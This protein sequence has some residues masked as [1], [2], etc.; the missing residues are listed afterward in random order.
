MTFWKSLDLDQPDHCMFWAP[1][2]LGYFGFLWSAEFTLSS[3]STFC[4]LIH[5]TV[6]DIA[7]DLVVPSCLCI[8][9]KSSKADPFC[10]GCCVHIGLGNSRCAV[11]AMT[12]YLAVRGDP[13]APYFNVQ[14]SAPF[15]CSPYGLAMTEPAYCWNRRGFLESQFLYWG[16]HRCCPEQ[17]S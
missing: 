2:T 11:H 17:I 9:I 12:A 15:L 14:W 7:V 3:L 5:L 16:C 6:G 8:K 4:P 1:C 10:K 13:L